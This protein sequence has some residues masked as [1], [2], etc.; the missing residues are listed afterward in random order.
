MP[1]LVFPRGACFANV[2]LQEAGFDCV[3]VDCDTS[4]S[5]TREE[6][7]AA[8]ASPAS[9]QGNLNPEILRSGGSV[10]GVEA[11]VR[12]LLLEAGPKNLI[13]N[14]SL[15]SEGSCCLCLGIHDHS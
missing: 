12:N 11:A 14:V 9:I 1:L 3:T 13:A 5:I 6:L 8:S 10:A 2:M 15:L 4:M 7:A